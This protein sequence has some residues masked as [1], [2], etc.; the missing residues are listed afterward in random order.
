MRTFWLIAVSGFM[1]VL[2]VLSI[3]MLQVY[4][5][6]S[7]DNLQFLVE[8]GS[9]FKFY[10]FSTDANGLHGS[11]PINVVYDFGIYFIA[12]LVMLYFKKAFMK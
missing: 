9:P 1:S 3:G 4:F 11:I 7:V 10:W 2:T 6:T 8:I 12:W 5:Q